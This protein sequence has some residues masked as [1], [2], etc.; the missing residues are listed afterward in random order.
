MPKLI[1]IVLLVFSICELYSQTQSLIL[2]DSTAN[3]QLK[4]EFKIPYCTDQKL[5]FKKSENT[6]ISCGNNTF[7]KIELRSINKKSGLILVYRG[8]SG[9]C[10]SKN[11]CKKE[12]TILKE[13]TIKEYSNYQLKIKLKI[14]MRLEDIKKEFTSL[15]EFHEA[16]QESANSEVLYYLQLEN[17]DYYITFKNDGEKKVIQQILIQPH[18]Q[19]EEQ[20]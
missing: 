11:E 5:P 20:R 10:L 9:N 19:A 2:V 15:S 14:G 17:F 18:L 4:I 8:K 3:E 6:I 1:S 12:T 7:Q 13:V 16:K